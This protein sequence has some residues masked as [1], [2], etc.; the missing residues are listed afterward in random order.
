M[1]KEEKSEYEFNELK[2]NFFVE[3]M[4]IDLT[5]KVQSI[6][7]DDKGNSLHDESWVC[8]M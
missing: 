4:E 2:S 7:T 3:Q 1:L 5:N 8:A 6:Y